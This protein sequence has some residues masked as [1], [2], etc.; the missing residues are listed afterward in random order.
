L[1]GS[2]GQLDREVEEWV[3]NGKLILPGTPS[4]NADRAGSLEMNFEDRQ[5]KCV[6]FLTHELDTFMK[7]ME[8][9]D[10]F[11][12]PRSYPV[13]WEIRDEIER[14]VGEVIRGINSIV[15][16]AEL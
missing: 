14:S 8:S 3:L 10:K 1:G 15:K 5:A 6:A 7:S 13:S 11:A 9:L 12:D 16:E 4:V 2:E